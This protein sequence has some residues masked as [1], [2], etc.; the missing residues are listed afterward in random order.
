VDQQIM[1]RRGLALAIGVILLIIIVVAVHGCLSS[2]HKAAL[3]DYNLKVTNVISDNNS[4]VIKPLFQALQSGGTPSALIG[5]LQTIAQAASQDAKQAQGFSAPS[6]MS[7]AQRNL[8]LVLNLRSAAV[9]EI[10]AQI[11]TA[12]STTGTGTGSSAAAQA[13]IDNITGQM[14]ALLASDVVYSQRVYPQIHEALAN[15]GVKDQVTPQSKS[16]T[17]FGWLDN[18]Q[19]T[20]AIGATV[21]V[22]RPNGKPAPGTHGHGLDSVKVN[23]VTLSTTGTNHVPAKPAPVFNVAFTNQGENAEIDVRVTV[24]VSA[25][26]S[27]KIKQSKTLPETKAGQSA[28]AT[29]P[30]GATPPS[31]PTLV[32]VTI[33]KVPGEKFTSNNHASYTVVFGS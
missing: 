24:T 3:K 26:G 25:P 11:P 32:S 22:K 1:V 28:V 29:I 19:V 13:A 12:L 16:L 27:A 6:E 23:G 10:T 30:L 15:G 17:N 7:Q 4:Q 21:P 2:R 31:G 33:G 8:E 20:S 14:Q 9:N 18:A 5:D